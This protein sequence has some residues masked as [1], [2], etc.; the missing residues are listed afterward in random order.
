MVEHFVQIPRDVLPFVWQTRWCCHE[1]PKLVPRFHFNDTGCLVFYK[2]SDEETLQHHLW[3]PITAFC[4]A[5][6]NAWSLPVISHR[7]H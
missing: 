5:C 1:I 6:R 7:V 4:P 2:K 3:M